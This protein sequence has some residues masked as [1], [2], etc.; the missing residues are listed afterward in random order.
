NLIQN[1]TVVATT[2]GASV[3]WS[4]ERTWASSGFSEENNNFPGD[5]ANPSPNRK[6]MLGTMDMQA[7]N[8]PPNTDLVHSN[9]VNITGL[10]DDMATG[11][12]V[13]IYTLGGVGS[14]RG[15]TYTVNGV[16]QTHLV[17]DIA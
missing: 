14:G 5:N 7:G 16:V 10:P 9:R 11:Y 12:D 2:T 13:I 15:G 4:A 3:S 17:G 1:T 6:L 8:G